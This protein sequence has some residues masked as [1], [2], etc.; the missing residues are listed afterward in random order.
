M[1]LFR[2]K[3]NAIREIERGIKRWVEVQEP[4]ASD[5]HLEDYL[6]VWIAFSPSISCLDKHLEQLRDSKGIEKPGIHNKVVNIW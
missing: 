6:Y 1:K 2:E 3:R 5:E 4:N